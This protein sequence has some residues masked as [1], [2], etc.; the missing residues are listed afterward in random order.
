MQ[1]EIN[2]RL[3]DEKK[4]KINRCS[5]I[6]IGKAVV[7]Q[8]KCNLVISAFDFLEFPSHHRLNWTLAVSFALWN[9]TKMCE[10]SVSVRTCA[11]SCYAVCVWKFSLAWQQQQ[12]RWWCDQI[13]RCTHISC[14][15]S[16]CA[17]NLI[18]NFLKWVITGSW[19]RFQIA[20]TWHFI[21]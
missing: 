14:Y 15:S 19:L 17:H 2:K 1:F 16:L 12:R 5:L 21:R 7:M 4:N 9:S 18:F 11:L 10:W 6:G 3:C 13:T 8:T 20:T